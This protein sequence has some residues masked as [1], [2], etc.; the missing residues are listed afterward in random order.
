MRG[1]DLDMEKELLKEIDQLFNFFDKN[2]DN[3]ITLE[4]LIVAFRS[5]NQNISINEAKEMMRMADKDNS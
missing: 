5:V 2:N 3:S 4:E 1:F